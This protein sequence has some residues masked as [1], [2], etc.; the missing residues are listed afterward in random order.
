MIIKRMNLMMMEREASC[1]PLVRSNKDHD[2]DEG[3]DKDGHEDE[4]DYGYW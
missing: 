2:N 1:Y 3:E 4:S